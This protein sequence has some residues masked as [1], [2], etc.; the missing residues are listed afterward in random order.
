MMKEQQNPKLESTNTFKPPTLGEIFQTRPAD[1][2]F[3]QEAA[4]LFPGIV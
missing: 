4:P 1:N 2:V 3:K